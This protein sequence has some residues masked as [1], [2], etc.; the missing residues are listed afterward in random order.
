MKQILFAQQ[1]SLG[2]MSWQ[3]MA[4]RAS[5][6]DSAKFGECVEARP[7]IAKIQAGEEMAR[8]LGVRGTPTI[9][10]N[11]WMLG[12]VPSASDLERLIAMFARGENPFPELQ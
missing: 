12:A 10:V 7:D 3:T 1:D 8:R 4:A 6:A 11:G 9:V 2:L 5:V